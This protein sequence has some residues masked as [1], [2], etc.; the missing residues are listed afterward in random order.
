MPDTVRVDEVPSGPVD[1]LDD[2]NVVAP[3]AIFGQ[4]YAFFYNKVVG[5]VLILLTGLL[6]LFGVLFPQM[7]A[8]VRTDPQAKASWL[9]SVRGTFGGWTDI[10]DTI[11]FFSMFAS[12]PFLIVMALLAASIIA[13]TVHRLPVLWQAAQHPHTRV[14]AAFF[15]RAR[16]RSTYI[17]SASPQVAFDTICADAR[18]H[19]MRVIVDDRGPGLNAYLDRN[20]WAPFGTVF[21]HAAFVIIMA[22]FVVSA[23]TG[24]R[25]DQ[26]P[27]TVGMPREVGFGTG[28]VVEATAFQDS[29]YPDGTPKDYVAD[30]V[31]TSDGQQ[32]AA[33]QI[34][35]NSPLSYDG[36]MFHQAYFGVSA[37]VRITD[38]AGTEEFHNGIAQEWTTSDGLYTY[39]HIT[40]GDQEIYAIS[41]ASGQT[42]TGIEPGQI[43]VEV[44]DAA[45]NSPLD[46]QIVDMGTP[47]RVGDHIVTFEREQQFTGLIIKKDPGTGIV[48]VGF[49]LLII[50]TCMT[51]FF[52]HHRAW[53]RVTETDEGTRVQIGS[54]DRQDS[55]FTRFFTD[56][57]IRTSETMV[58]RDERNA[59]A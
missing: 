53:L 54:P 4:I 50:G 19:R 25:T 9:E 13:C 44:Y 33:Q 49:A 46:Q 58:H 23:T 47:T 56:L 52:R 17:T 32:V 20:H 15:D 2:A 12:V 3:S 41:S 59:H 10:L 34:R 16:L 39:G 48:W 22:G 30:L 36:I 35:V 43:R 7:P 57:V 42:Q 27:L 28:L 26:F 37:V 45:T 5:L 40:V 6:G 24:F 11:G 31:L 14:T 38:A 1:G 51:M 21:A 8:G 29:Y 18:A 55:G